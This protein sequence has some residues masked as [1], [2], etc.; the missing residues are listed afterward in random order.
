MRPALLSLSLALACG[1]V[2]AS[3][4]AP[5]VKIDRVG[6]RSRIDVAA[7]RPGCPAREPDGGTRQRIL[8]AAALE[9]AAFRFP[10]LDLAGRRGLAV[11]P[12]GL[13]PRISDTGSGGPA[14]RLVAIGAM[15]DDRAVRERIGRYWAA[16]PDHYRG[17]F[18]Q[19]NAIWAE[20]DRA[21]WAEY[22]SAAFVSY[23]MCAAGLSPTAFARSDTHRDYIAAALEARAGE[24]PGHL[25]HAHDLAEAPPRPGDLVCAAR[26]DP[27]GGIRDLAEFRA[28]AEHGAFH[29]DIV[30]GFDSRRPAV[31]YA[32]GGNVLNAVTLTATPLRGGRLVPVPGFGGRPW[33]AL[34]RFV[35]PDGP[36]SF[37]R[38]PDAVRAEAKRIRDGRAQ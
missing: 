9:W 23:V 25:Y 21:G 10:R 11:I 31:A 1:P 27:A 13:S 15:E 22:W 34:L 17:V 29:C 26:A 12:D 35:G 32:I 16:L 28:R 24:R 4:E 36:A 8:D 19:Q 14:P 20:N 3:A 37:R 30:V 2:S 5:F 6:G 38:V 18:R 7:T 33:F